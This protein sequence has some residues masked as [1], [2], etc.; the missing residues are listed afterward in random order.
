ML[1]RL[2][3]EEGVMFFS[4]VISL[5]FY[6][7]TFLATIVYRGFVLEKFFRHRVARIVPIKMHAPHMH[8]GWRKVA[9]ISLRLPSCG[10][11]FEVLRSIKYGS[12]DKKG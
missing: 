10:M 8:I 11:G 6:I 1:F 2:A 7:G 9:S 3:Q 5:Q 12:H 4:A